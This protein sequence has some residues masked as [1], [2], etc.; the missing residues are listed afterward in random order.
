MSKRQSH[1][2]EQDAQLENEHM[3]CTQH[4][5]TLGKMQ[6]KTIERY[7]DTSIRMAKI[8]ILNTGEDVRELDLSY[9]AGEKIRF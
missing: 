6:I 9:T 7:H 2:P 4:C 3:K 5:D 1:L 8:K